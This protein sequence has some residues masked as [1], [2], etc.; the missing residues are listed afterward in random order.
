MGEVVVAPYATFALKT[1]NIIANRAPARI[2]IACLCPESR[3]HAIP[4]FSPGSRPGV[5]PRPRTIFRVQSAR[6]PM[7]RKSPLL[8]FLVP[9]LAPQALAQTFTTD[10]SP[11][12]PSFSPGVRGQ[13]APAVT[14]DRGEYITGIPKA[15]A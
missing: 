10:A 13:A 8:T 9:P 12:G 7:P 1:T 14:I 5:M 6:C 11:P 3:P 2:F 4:Q 15:V